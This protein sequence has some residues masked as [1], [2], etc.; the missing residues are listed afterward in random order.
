MNQLIS[1]LLLFKLS[2]EVDLNFKLVLCNSI[3]AWLAASVG[4]L[5]LMGIADSPEE[6]V[7]A[8]HEHAGPLLYMLSMFLIFTFF[9]KST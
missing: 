2:I 7:V 4:I 3:V 6:V 5:R 1:L 8:L 9:S